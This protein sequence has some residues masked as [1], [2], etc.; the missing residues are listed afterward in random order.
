MTGFVVVTCLAHKINYSESAEAEREG[1]GWLTY[2]Q[3]RYQ[4]NFNV[5]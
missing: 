4:L 5:S 2:H 1:G 3:F